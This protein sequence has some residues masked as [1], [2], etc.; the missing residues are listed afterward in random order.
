MAG[1]SQYLK[2]LMI[3]FLGANPDLTGVQARAY[4]LGILEAES[5]EDF[6][7]MNRLIQEALYGQKRKNAA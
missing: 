1:Y 4:A 7:E 3:D 6:I 2:D 5:R